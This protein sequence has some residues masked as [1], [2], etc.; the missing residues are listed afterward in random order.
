M[1]LVYELMCVLN[2]ELSLEKHALY[3]SVYLIVF[4]K[5]TFLFILYRLS[6][7]K[8]KNLSKLFYFW[9]EFAKKGPKFWQN[10]EIQQGLVWIVNY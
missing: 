3:Y 4:K 7:F 9:L 2:T 6:F 10:E 8:V 5:G 1:L